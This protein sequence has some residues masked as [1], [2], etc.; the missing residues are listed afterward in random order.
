MKVAA[1]NNNVR[2]THNT[3][4]MK[5]DINKVCSDIGAVMLASGL[6]VDGVNTVIRDGSFLGYTEVVFMFPD[7]TFDDEGEW[8]DDQW[9]RAIVVC[10][11]LRKETPA[12]DDLST[13]EFNTIL[14]AAKELRESGRIVGAE[15]S[16]SDLGVIRIR[17]LDLP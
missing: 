5:M 9:L 12:P 15:V 17:V 3:G 11:L 10:D 16:D 4:K 8:L 13:E 1:Y 14:E 6:N 2:T 7:S